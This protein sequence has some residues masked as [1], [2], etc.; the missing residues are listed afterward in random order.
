MRGVSLL[1]QDY[2]YPKAHNIIEL[3]LKRIKEK[4]INDPFDIEPIYL[5]PKE[6]QIRNA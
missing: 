1:G 3:A 5:Y 6:C 2:W 4:K